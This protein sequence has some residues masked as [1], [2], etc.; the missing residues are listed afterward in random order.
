[1][2]DES[3]RVPSNA[4]HGVKALDHAR[5]VHAEALDFNKNFITRA[6]IGVFFRQIA[7]LDRDRLVER[8]AQAGAGF[9]AKARLTEVAILAPVLVQRATWVNRAFV[10]T[11][12]ALI[13]LAL[14][15]AD[16]VVR[17]AP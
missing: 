7:Y 14:A 1:M 16:Y 8:G 6:Q 12:G 9:E 17:V 11:A 13:A 4:G 10:L 2:P 5:G 15:S 3:Q